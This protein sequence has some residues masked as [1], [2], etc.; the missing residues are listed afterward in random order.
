MSATTPIEC[1]MSRMPVL[2]LSLSER[3][4]SRMSAWT[5]TSRA[6]VGSSAMMALGLHEIA[7]AMHTRWRW[8]PDSSC[9]YCLTR[10]SAS[11]KPTILS[12]STAR[13]VAA[14]P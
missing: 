1:V 11:F 5:V 3:S 6:V 10:A 7:M 14:V 12:S 8:P 2:S 9:G 13:A 4:R